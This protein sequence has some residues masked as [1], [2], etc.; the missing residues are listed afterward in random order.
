MK[1]NKINFIIIIIF[2]LLLGGSLFMFKSFEIKNK[3]LSKKYRIPYP[4]I[5]AHRGLSY[6]A[7]EETLPAYLLALEI[8]E[9]LYLEAD[10]QRTKDGVLVCFHDDDLKR[11]TN[12]KD[13]FPDKI[14]AGIGD[15]TYKE[16][17]QLD[18]GSWFNEKF[19]DRARASFKGLKIFTLEE[20][21]NLAKT[22]PT[23]G[24]Y[25]E[26]KS[27]QKYPGI[28]KEL[29][30]LL[31]KMGWIDSEQ[32]NPQLLKEKKINLKDKEISSS[33]YSKV[34][35]QSFEIESLKLLKEYAPGVPRVYLVDEDMQKK[36]G[37][38]SKL[39]EMAKS[40]DAHLG[41]IGYMGY[42]WNIRRSLANDILTHHYTINEKYQ[43]RLL[44]I[45]GS[46]GIFTDK[47]NVALQYFFPE[48]YPKIDVEELF[49]KIQF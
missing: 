36:Y 15:L 5:M 40:V 6:Y 30:L 41:P 13:V 47:A 42:P 7:P 45:F 26:T 10:I 16:L 32:I 28:E 25:L 29:V 27:P 21:V 33:T 2:F 11:T 8:G 39:V 12:I 34:I 20:L 24:L 23:L 48:K 49:K 37:G 31:Y 38:F 14:D 19:P 4:A 3:E 43:M 22:K 17:L 46:S 35:F 9:D 18:L 44:R 1:I